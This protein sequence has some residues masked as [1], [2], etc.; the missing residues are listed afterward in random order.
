MRVI[1]GTGLCPPAPLRSDRYRICLAGN[2]CSNGGGDCDNI[3]EKI[4]QYI[5]HPIGRNSRIIFLRI[6]IKGR[7]IDCNFLLINYYFTIRINR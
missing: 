4:R 7:K 6:L 5:L 2:V 1:A 3:N